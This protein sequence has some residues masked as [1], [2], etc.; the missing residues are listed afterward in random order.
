MAFHEQMPRRRFIRIGFTAAGAILVAAMPDNRQSYPICS[1]VPHV[2][3]QGIRYNA[4][5]VESTVR[6]PEASRFG[7]DFKVFFPGMTGGGRYLTAIRQEI[8][9]IAGEG[10]AL[11]VSSI[12]SKEGL[13]KGESSKARYCNQA[14]T[15]TERAQGRNLNWIAHSLGIWESVNTLNELLDNTSWDGKEIKM[16]FVSP[17]GFGQEDLRAIVEVA[18]GIRALTSSVS[19]VEQHMA[20]PGP[21]SYYASLPPTQFQEDVDVLF[22]DSPEDRATRRASFRDGLQYIIPNQQERS[23]FLTA[24]DDIDGRIANA[25]ERSEPIEELLIARKELLAPYIQAMFRGE[26][27]PEEIH[28]KYLARYQELE[29]YLEVPLWQQANFLLF[30]AQGVGYLHHGMDKVLANIINKA[31]EKGKKITFDFILQ[32]KD[33]MV[34]ITKIDLLKEGVTAHQLAEAFRGFG[35]TGDHGHSTFGYF[36]KSI[37]SIYAH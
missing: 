30:L 8:D 24:I 20:Y 19:G 31:R 6:F 28:Q 7:S 2:S 25:L 9:N 12:S 17:I 15:I 22:R 11:V 16:H 5:M 21:E 26:H 36:T 37:A 10:N 13:R 18:R 34:P 33:A 23:S 35:V 4:G 3:G 14:A 29:E 27:I 1:A 32:E